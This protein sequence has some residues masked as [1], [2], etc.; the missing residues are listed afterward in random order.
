M[1]SKAHHDA[2]RSNLK[3]WTAL[4]FVGIQH[5]EADETGPAERLELR[6]CS[7]G[8]TLARKLDDEAQQVTA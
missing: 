6:D 5:V 4:R 7:C 1:C 8:S 3:L 2:L